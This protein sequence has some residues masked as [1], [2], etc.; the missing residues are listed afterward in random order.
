MRCGEKAKSAGKGVG[1][2]LAAFCLLSAGTNL[3]VQHE[4]K[5]QGEHAIE[6]EDSYAEPGLEGR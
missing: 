4:I 6:T 1:F 5:N 2:T 3:V